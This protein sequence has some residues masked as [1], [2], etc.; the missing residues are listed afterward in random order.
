MKTNPNET[1]AA[2]L[3]QARMQAG[4]KNAAEFARHARI[5]QITYRAHENGQRG[6]PVQTAKDYAKR[7]N[8]SAAWLL[9]G[10]G[11]DEGPSAIP[12][13]GY[14]GAGHQIHPMDDFALG[15]GLDIVDSPPTYGEPAPAVAVEVRG[16]SMFPVYREGDQIYYS[17]ERDFQIEEM[18]NRESVVQLADGRTLLKTIRRGPTPGR[19]SLDSY[20][21]SPIEDVEIR[22]AAPIIWIRRK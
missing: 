8:C 13:V 20:N 1:A 16:D 15:A 2:R 10:E 12:L 6:I 17:R 22:W 18:I 9:T 3:R 4:F 7:L 11:P 21:A 5:S 14:V 19:Y